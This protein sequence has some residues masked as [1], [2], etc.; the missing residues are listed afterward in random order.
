MTNEADRL[1]IWIEQGNVTISQLFFKF[2]KELGIQDL[3]AMLIM[4]LTAFHEEGN[5][6]PTPTDIANRMQLTEDEIAS[7]LQR[8]MQKGFI[9]ILQKVDE[10]GVLFETFNLQPL[11]A[12]L[13]DCMTEKTVKKVEVS[14]KLKE[15][16]LFNLF[17]Q[18][19]GRFLS[20]MESET[21]SM[22][23]DQDGHSPEVIRKALIEAVLSQKLSLRYV[24]R[25]LFE[26]KKKNV[27][28]PKD[29]EKLAQNFRQNTLPSRPQPTHVEPQPTKKVPFYNWLEERE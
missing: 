12:R 1:R 29:A 27:K 8:M 18:E 3:D 21:I 4:H 10:H 20:P 9:E 26:W 7:S 5:T 14:S 13:V 11:W 22:W 28:T 19:F 6:F 15:G 2:Y 24:D 23:L 25:I 17:E 16:E